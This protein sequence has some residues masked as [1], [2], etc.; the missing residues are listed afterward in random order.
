MNRSK[1]SIFIRFWK[2]VHIF[3]RTVLDTWL[4]PGARQ[5]DINSCSAGNGEGDNIFRSVRWWLLEAW[6]ARLRNCL[7]FWDPQIPISPKIELNLDRIFG[8]SS[9]IRSG[10]Y[11]THYVFNQ[12]W[13]SSC[14][15][16]SKSEILRP[17]GPQNIRISKPWNQ[18]TSFRRKPKGLATITLTFRTRSARRV[19]TTLDRG[20]EFDNLHSINL[21][22]MHSSETGL[23]VQ[24]PPT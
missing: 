20:H 24:V 18:S 21:I 10:W 8:S 13:L 9:K 2:I 5:Q 14:F 1:N 23:L 19:E 3:A 17:L 22:L 7:R 4:S 6:R 15:S 11:Q 12:I 16:T